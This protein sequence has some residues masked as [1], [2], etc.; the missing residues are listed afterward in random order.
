[1]STLTPQQIAERARDAMWAQ[2]ASGKALGITITAIAP[3]R[4][5]ATMRVRADMLNGFAICH[6]GFITTLADHSVGIKTIMELAGHRQLGTTQRYIE[7]TPDQ[8]RKAVEL[9][10]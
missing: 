2:D 6:G 8:K 3:G 10:S 7:V 5:T 1:M 9:I 4:A